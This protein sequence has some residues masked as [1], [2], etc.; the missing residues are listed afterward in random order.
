MDVIREKLKEKA[1][2]LLR[3]STFPACRTREEMKAAVSQID[4]MVEVSGEF[5]QLQMSLMAAMA[6]VMPLLIEKEI[7]SEQET[8]CTCKNHANSRESKQ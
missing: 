4:R 1:E 7:A 3:L 5:E 2:E 6:I 8:K